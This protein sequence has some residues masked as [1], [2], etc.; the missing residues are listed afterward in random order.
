V[1][2]R[3]ILDQF[4]QLGLAGMAQAFAELEAYGL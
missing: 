3:P 1:L 4:T 2:I